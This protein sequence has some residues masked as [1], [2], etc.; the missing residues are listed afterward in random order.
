LG[1]LGRLAMARPNSR[2]RRSQM[3]PDAM[4]ILSA[5]EGVA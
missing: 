1:R 4:G 5:L 3:L 2:A